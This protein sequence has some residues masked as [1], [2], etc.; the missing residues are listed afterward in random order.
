M[1]LADAAIVGAARDTRIIETTITGN[2]SNFVV[3]KRA[4]IELNTPESVVLAA[5]YAAY[6]LSAIDAILSRH[7]DSDTDLDSLA[8]TAAAQNL[9]Q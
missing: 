1:K 6:E 5:K 7:N 8:A 2:T 3:D 4:S 9:M